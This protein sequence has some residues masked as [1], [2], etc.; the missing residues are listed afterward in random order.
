MSRDHSGDDRGNDCA[1][2]QAGGRVGTED[3]EKSSGD[4]LPS[5]LGARKMT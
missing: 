4:D 2:E 5:N 3:T 1:R